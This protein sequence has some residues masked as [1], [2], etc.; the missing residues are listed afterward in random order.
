MIFPGRYSF[1]LNPHSE[2]RI[3]EALAREDIYFAVVQGKL[4][5]PGVSGGMG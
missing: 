4:W 5:E 1:F 2:R 3:R